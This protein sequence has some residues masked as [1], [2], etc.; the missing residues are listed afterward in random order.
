MNIRDFLRDDTEAIVRLYV[1]TVRRVNS[2]DYAPEQI[3]AWAPDDV[4]I[5]EWQERLDNRYTYVAE[6]EGKIVG[7]ID[8]EPRGCIDCIYCHAEH[9][10][11][12]IGTA[13]LARCEKHAKAMGLGRLYTE[14]SITARPFLE[15]HGY[16]VTEEHEVTRKGVRFTNFHMEKRI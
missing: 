8:L 10:G 5:D 13:L 4:N 11:E 9:Q 2:R 14:A 15:K 16:T 7:F 1:E 3:A 6:M 12:G